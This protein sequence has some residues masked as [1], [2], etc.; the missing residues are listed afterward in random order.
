MGS[1]RLDAGYEDYPTMVWRRGEKR[2][3]LVAEQVMAKDV[4]RENLPKERLILLAAATAF[5]VEGIGVYLSSSRLAGG[6]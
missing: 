4:G 5:N 3:K 2:N 1:D 6:A